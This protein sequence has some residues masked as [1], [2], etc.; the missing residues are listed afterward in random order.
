MIHPLLKNHSILFKFGK[1]WTDRCQSLTFIGNK[2]QKHTVF[3]ISS[4][5]ASKFDHLNEVQQEFEKHFNWNA[6][7]Y[8]K[9]HCI[10]SHVCISI[11]RLVYTCVFI[12]K[13]DAV[14][15]HVIQLQL[16]IAS[17]CRCLS[18]MLHSIMCLFGFAQKKCAPKLTTKN[19][20]DD[21]QLKI[22]IAES[23]Q[24]DFIH[25]FQW[26]WHKNANNCW[27]TMINFR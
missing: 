23:T 15:T 24:V 16:P 11:V 7:T 18:Q 6:K 21:G 10:N 5:L 8:P 13:Y 26:L 4:Q 9:K 27:R 3:Y 12:I 14:R 22:I 20:R 19:Y 2:T 25:S 1:K 17:E